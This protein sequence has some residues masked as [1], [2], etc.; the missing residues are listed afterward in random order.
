ETPWAEVLDGKTGL[1]FP[2]LPAGRY[3]LRLWHPETGEKSFEVNVGAGTT[4]GEWTLSASLPP[5]EPHKNK[6]GKDYPP[7]K[8]EGSY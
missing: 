1:A 3:L 6:F 8:D 4:V 7:T 5:F 2:D